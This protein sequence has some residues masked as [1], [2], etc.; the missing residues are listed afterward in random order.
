MHGLRA[1]VLAFGLL[2]CTLGAARARAFSPAPTEPP[3][4][5]QT[6]PA[7]YQQAAALGFMEF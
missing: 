7:G 2:C 6:A 5:A 3:A 4:A 1:S